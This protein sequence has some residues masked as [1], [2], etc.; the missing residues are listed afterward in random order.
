M[1]G[2]EGRDDVRNN[3]Q[4]YKVGGRDA[5]LRSAGRCCSH[6]DLLRLG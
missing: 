2:G 6:L 4:K 1:G 3:T 5:G